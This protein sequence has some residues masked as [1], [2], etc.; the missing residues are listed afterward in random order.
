MSER[1]I[2]AYSGGLDTSVAISWIGK[3]TGSEV[4]AVAIDLG[5]GRR[6]HGGRASACA[7]LRRSGSRCGRRRDEFAEQYCLP[8]IQSNALYMDRYPLVSALSRPLIVKHLVAAA[9]EHGGD[10]VAH[11]CTGRVMTR[12][13][14][15][16]VRLA[17]TGFGRTRTGPRLRLD[18]GEGHR[19]RRG[20][21]HPDQ[22]HQ[23]LAVLDRPER[24]GPCGGNRLPGTPLERAHERRLRLHR[25]PDAELE[26]PDEVVIGF[27]QGVPVAIDGS[28]V[29]VLEAIVEL[30]RRAGAQGVGRLDVVEDRLVG[31]KSREI[32][33]APGP[34]C[35]LPRTPNSSTSPS[36]ANWQVQTGHRPALVR[37]GLR[38]TLVLSAQDRVGGIRRQDPGAGDGEIRM[39]LHGGH[40]RQRPAQPP[41]VVR[42]QPG[43]LRR[44]RHL[45]P[46]L[47]QGFRPHSRSV[48]QNRRPP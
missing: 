43:H 42:L 27:E 20:E 23:T 12:S 1:V 48:V 5:Q 34:W 33:E 41:V 6:G 22:R 28:K 45:R 31:I 46:V 19:L 30:N 38:R 9:R 13:G 16:L 24:L 37:T 36:N 11:G 29:S 21:R 35:S 40:R 8:A 25:R 39:V 3:E 17:G 15:R 47:G 44:G 14:S 2:L 7:G 32:Y 4:V 26:H 18:A 10:V